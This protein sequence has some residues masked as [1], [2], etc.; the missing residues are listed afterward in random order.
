MTIREFAVAVKVLPETLSVKQG[1][2][3]LT[4]LKVHTNTDRSCIVLDCSKVHLMD[5][6]IIHVLLCC[7]EEAM[8]HNGDVRLAKVNAGARLTLEI[9]GVGRL[10]EIFETTED[11][12]NSF[13][14][15]TGDWTLHMSVPD[16]S[17]RAT[18]DAA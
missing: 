10:F 15:H 13:Q 4:E 18:P 12:L 3:F 2:L 7:L 11:A 5:K 14:L 8:K 16:S 9:T 17:H 6:S 1:R